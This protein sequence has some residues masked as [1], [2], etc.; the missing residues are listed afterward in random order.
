MT[1]S[2]ATVPLSSQSP[3]HGRAARAIVASTASAALGTGPRPP[4]HSSTSNVM[5]ALRRTLLTPKPE[6]ADR[7]RS[8]CS[9][10]LLMTTSLRTR[11]F[12][13]AVIEIADVCSMRLFESWVLRL[14]VAPARL[15]FAGKVTSSPSE[16]M[17][18]THPVVTCS[19]CPSSAAAVGRARRDAGRRDLSAGGCEVGRGDDGGRV[20][21]RFMRPTIRR[22]A[23]YRRWNLREI[24]VRRW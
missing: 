11:E 12:L 10:Q 21:L 4:P 22:A 18:T 16:V 3:M 9:L 19:I 23:R 15:W 8:Q 6:K 1:S 2:T 14:P 20:R 5:A 24:A 13:D 7:S 17:W